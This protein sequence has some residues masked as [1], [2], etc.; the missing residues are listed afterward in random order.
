MVAPMWHAFMEYALTKYPVSYFPE[1]PGIPVGAP[2]ALQG[3]Y[4]GPSGVHDILYWVD[5]NNPEGPPPANPAND[6]QFAAWEYPIQTWANG[7]A[8]S[9]TAVLPTVPQVLGTTTP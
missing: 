2:A 1:A 9:P 4:Q 8:T 5:K 6:P 7:A 3:V